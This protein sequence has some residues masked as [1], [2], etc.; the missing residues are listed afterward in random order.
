MFLRER[1]E[2]IARL[3]SA[4]GRVT[5]AGLARRFDVTED[6]IRKDLR[7]L[8][9]AGALRKVYGGA[10]SVSSSPERSVIKRVGA[11]SAE[12]RLVAEKAFDMIEPG[13]TI[14]LDVS[15][16]NLALAELL[17]AGTKHVSV[18][19]TMM[20]ILRV[21]ARNPA[22]EVLGTG[23]S[24]NTELDGFMGSMTL[25]CLRPLR[26]DRAF[27][28][29]LGVDVE[30]GEVTTY[31]WDDAQ[32]KQLAMANSSHCLLMVD[33]HKFGAGGSYVYAHVRDFDGIVTNRVT[34]ELASAVEGLGSTLV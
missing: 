15:T 20:G 3:V 9:A 7:Q 11:H 27:L 5:V 23:G 17:S 14:F 4:E 32:V 19:S 29:G 2:E 18:V 28:G 10:V 24:V 22:L 21:L 1:Q 31:L 30:S 13:E 8:E 33:E 26:F 6:C 16:T 12:K 25:A 34:T